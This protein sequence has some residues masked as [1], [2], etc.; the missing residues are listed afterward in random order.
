MPTAYDVLTCLT[1]TD[2][3]TFEE[4]CSEFGYD[5]DSRKAE[6]TY[7]ACV[8]EYFGVHRLFGDVMDGL[9]EIQ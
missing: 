9:M 5:T 2:P 6:K 4:F 1:K 8:K 7:K 3:G